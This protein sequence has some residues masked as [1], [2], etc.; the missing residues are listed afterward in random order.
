M[1]RIAI[2]QPTYLP[3]LGYFQQIAWADYFVFLDVVQFEKQSWQSRNRIRD[4]EGNLIWLSVPVADQGLNEPIRNIRIA[5]Q[6]SNWRR[7]HLNSIQT[8]LGKTPHIEQ[9][10]G[11]LE[12][13]YNRDHEYLTDLNIDIIDTVCRQLGIPTKLLR[14]S[15]LPCQG[16]KADLLLSIIKYMGCDLYRANERSR[17]YLEP[18]MPRFS[19]EGVS[20]EFQQWSQPNYQQKGTGFVPQL[21]WVDAVSYLGFNA[22]K[23]GLQRLDH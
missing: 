11:L 20:I 23:L 12:E 17:G 18:E 16:R 5:R 1:S 21:S 7:K 2:A 14:A 22:T 15:E 8:L 19:R 13:I 3:W 6:K 10:T 4:L 9:V